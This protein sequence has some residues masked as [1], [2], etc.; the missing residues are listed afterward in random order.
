[1]NLKYY[2]NYTHL[3]K[4][5]YDGAFIKKYLGDLNNHQNAIID[6]F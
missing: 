1:M 2:A 4:C 5:L 3:S 6:E